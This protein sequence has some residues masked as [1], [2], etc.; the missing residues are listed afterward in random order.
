MNF[1]VEF[2]ISTPW[3]VT[4][5]DSKRCRIVV[6]LRYIIL[7]TL[8]SC[9]VSVSVFILSLSLTHWSY[10]FLA[11]NHRYYI[12][13]IISSSWIPKESRHIHSLIRKSFLGPQIFC[14]SFFITRIQFWYMSGYEYEYIYIYSIY[15]Y[16]KHTIQWVQYNVRCS[17]KA[18]LNVK[19]LLHHQ[20]TLWDVHMSRRIVK[21]TPLSSPGTINLTFNVASENLG[22]HPT[23]VPFRC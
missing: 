20:T 17:A 19:V 3:D 15:P 12:G 18:K 16:K 9:K 2:N 14:V 1:S 23:T 10:V 22:S 21:K 8:A 5:I 13:H 6:M 4:D 11:L 7:S